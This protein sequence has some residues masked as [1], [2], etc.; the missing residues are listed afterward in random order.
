MKKLGKEEGRRKKE[1]DFS[2]YIE[3]GYIVYVYN[4]TPLLPYSPTP[5]SALFN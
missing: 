4:Y 5:L 1:E 3:S 2:F